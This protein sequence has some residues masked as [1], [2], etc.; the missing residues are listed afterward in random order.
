M[1]KEILYS[2]KSPYREPLDI[3]GF[4]FGS[5]SPS[6]AVVGA[7]RGNEIQQMYVCARLVRELRKLE[8]STGSLPERKFW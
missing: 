8:K 5:G 7:M 1:K 3:I 4:R 2:I 6:L